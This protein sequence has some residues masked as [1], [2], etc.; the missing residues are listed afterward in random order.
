MWRLA[1]TPAWAEVGP[2]WYWRTHSLGQAAQRFFSGFLEV[3]SQLVDACGAGPAQTKTAVGVVVLAGALHGLLRAAKGGKPQSAIAVA[4][5]GLPLLAAL[6]WGAQAG[7]SVIRLVFP[8]AVSLFPLAAESFAAAAWRGG[9]LLPREWRSWAASGL[10]A[11]CAG[12]AIWPAAWGLVGDPRAAWSVPADWA[13]TSEWLAATAGERGY[14]IPFDSAFSTWDRGVDLRQPYPFTAPDSELR[15]VIAE[16]RL[17]VVLV[18]RALPSGSIP[19]E[20]FGRDDRFG[21][22]SFLGWPRCFSSPGR[23]SRFIAF[24]KRCPAR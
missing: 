15:R 5:V 19:A 11:A 17:G 23:P 21:P 18:D 4:A 3:V 2:T 1:Q 14:L 8:V 22:T 24:A 10:A 9:S 6:S 16:R 20:R 12:L 13:A 7:I